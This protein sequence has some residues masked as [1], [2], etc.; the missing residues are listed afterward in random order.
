M[1]DPII[2]IKYMISGY[3]VILAVLAAY[4]VSLIMRWRNLKRTLRS[5]EEIQKRI[6][7]L[8]RGMID[9]YEAIKR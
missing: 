5:L 7:P 1:L 8:D 9:D 6:S 4:L 2:S 3:V